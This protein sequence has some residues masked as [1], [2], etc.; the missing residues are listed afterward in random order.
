MWDENQE[1]FMYTYTY[2]ICMKR[3]II[4]HMVPKLMELVSDIS[5]YSLRPVPLVLEPSEQRI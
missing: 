4:H 3:L 2:H 5:S 1:P